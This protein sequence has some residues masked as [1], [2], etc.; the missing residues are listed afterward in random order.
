MNSTL[1]VFALGIVAATTAAATALASIGP[2]WSDDQLAGF[3][4]AIV[5]GQ[6]LTTS[7]GRDPQTGAIYTYATLSVDESFKG[8]I[9]EPTIVIKQ[10]GGVLGDIGYAVADQATFTNGE[11]V[12]VFLET[13]PRDR[14]LYTVALWQ[15]K[16]TIERAT[17]T[18]ELIATRPWPH[19]EPGAA[20]LNIDQR[21]LGAFVS[22]L[23][24]QND[25]QRARDFVV[26][27][28][29]AEVARFRHRSS[30]LDPIVG[31]NTIAAR[32][33][34]LTCRLPVIRISPRPTTE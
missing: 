25:G 1:R 28:T 10:L 24:L 22:R 5:R 19:R 26:A 31:P 11:E 32:P 33:F 17:D 14:T 3:A 7:L 4:S 13:R 16:W 2:V 18:G 15:G 29:E 30:S 8:N 6:V 9:V 20:K 23:R 27:P 21:S 12:I 34:P